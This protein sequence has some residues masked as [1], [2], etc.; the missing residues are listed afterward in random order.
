VA[1]CAESQRSLPS[2]RSLALQHSQTTPY[3]YSLLRTSPAR[4][5]NSALNRTYPHPIH[6]RSSPRS[7]RPDKDSPS[8][9]SLQPL[10]L[11]ITAASEPVRKIVL[12]CSPTG[13]REL[14]QQ[15]STATHV[16]VTTTAHLFITDRFNRQ[17]FLINT[18]SN[19]C[20]FPASSFRIAK[21]VSVII[22]ARLMAPKDDCLLVSIWDLTWR[23]VVASNL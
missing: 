20:V 4:W 8:E 18:G 17:R 10:P 15:T 23:I 11:G 22:S 12:I 1:R 2:R 6:R 3:F 13:S 16:C 7:R 19:F 21:R 5:Q 14:V 9:I